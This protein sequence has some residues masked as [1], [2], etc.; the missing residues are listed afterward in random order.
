MSITTYDELKSAIADWFSRSGDTLI[1]TPATDFIT[2]AEARFNYGSAHA[3][4]PSMPLRVRQM[5]TRSTATFDDEYI[6]LPGDFLEI[7]TLKLNTSPERIL[8]YLTPERFAE[9]A[10]SK[11]AETPNWYT[12]IGGELRLGPTPDSG[13]S[14]TGELWYYAK[15]PALSDSN[16]SNWL[17]AAKP[18]IYL[19]GALVEAAPYLL[20]DERLPLWFS[21]FQG[22][23][24]GLMFQDKRARVGGSVWVSRPDTPTP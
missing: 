5:E 6:A 18:D 10:A 1:T 20:G 12:I 16:T 19:Y 2:L 7:K 15:V 13:S 17:L 24:N 9:I 4:F 14:Y 11:T 8:R 23:L 22:A 3:Q 21:M